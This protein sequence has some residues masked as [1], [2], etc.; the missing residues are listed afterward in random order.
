LPNTRHVCAERHEIYVRILLTGDIDRATEQWLATH[1]DD[2]RADILQRPHPGSR[3]STHA[4][5]IQRVQPEV[6]IIT[7]GSGNSYGH[8]HPRVLATLEQ[9]NVR[10]FRTDLHG[11][12]TITSDGTQ[13]H[14]EPFILNPGSPLRPV[15]IPP[16]P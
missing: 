5:F 1:T 11:A 7:S 10:V 13:Y 8:P 12:I 16:L 15:H 9:H 3:T 2:L 14:I 4:D 6:G